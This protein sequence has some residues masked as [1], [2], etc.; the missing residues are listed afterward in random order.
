M[1]KKNLINLWNYIKMIFH[2]RDIKHKLRDMDSQSQLIKNLKTNSQMM[3]KIWQALISEEKNRDAVIEAFKSLKCNSA[4]TLLVQSYLKYLLKN[5]DEL[6]RKNNIP[7]WFRGGSLLGVVRHGGFI[8][9]DDDID[10]GIMRNDMYRLQEILKDTDFQIVYHFNNNL[11]QNIC[12]MPRFLN[13]KNGINIFIDLF[14]FDYTEECEKEALKTYWK[15]RRQLYDEIHPL[16]EN[17]T[18]A[19]YKGLMYED[20]SK[21]LDILNK[22]FDK[23]TEKNQ[24]A[25]AN[26]IYPFDW[27]D[28]TQNLYYKT[29]DIFPLKEMKFDD[30][31]VYVPNEFIL[32]LNMCYDNFLDFPSQFVD[33]K[34]CH[35][36]LTN[37]RH[38]K[39]FLLREKTR[40]NSK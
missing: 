32:A 14:P 31:D 11:P 2:I 35:K 7:Y 3:N 21:D 29:S 38:I 15:K 5:F 36:L 1:K 16:V 6:C 28:T 12:R 9:W 4:D 25:T 23:Y 8:P 27:F 10:L 24:V 37:K 18:I 19:R 13:V 20:N 40:A 39:K 26:V 30:I 17:H 22:I 34:D 33:H